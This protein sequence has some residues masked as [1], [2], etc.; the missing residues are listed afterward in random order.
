MSVLPTI[1][2]KKLYAILLKNGFILTA[3]KG[4]H[5]RMVHSDGRKTT[6]P[7]HS[8]QDLPKGLLRK[9]IREDLDISIEEFVAF[10]NK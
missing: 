2:G 1:S 3:I 9:I 7:I 8:N 5:H 10:I 4:S 6:I